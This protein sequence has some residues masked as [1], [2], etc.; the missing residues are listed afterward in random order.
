M[1]NQQIRM[2]R[3]GWG[4]IATGALFTAAA[5]VPA[6]HVVAV[7]FLQIAHWPFGTVPGDFAVPVPLLLVIGGGL[8][9][10]LGGLLVGAATHVV[11]LSAEAADKVVKYA[12]WSWFV[13]DSTGSV[14]VGAPFNAVLNLAF[15]GLILWSSRPTQQEAQ[16]PA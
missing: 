11:P 1:T 9:A 7:L 4:I 8:T 3:A 6:L 5:V 2:R 10:S 14:L 13:I 16:V 15:L 12:A